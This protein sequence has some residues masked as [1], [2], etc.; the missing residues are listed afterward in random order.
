MVWTVLRTW[1]AIVDRTSKTI[2]SISDDDLQTEI[3]PGRNR[4]YY[5][6][7]HLA[8]TQDRLFPLLRLGDRVYPQLDEQF[9]SNA[10]RKYP[11]GEA[12]PTE[13]RRAWMEVNATLAEAFEVL[14][15]EDWLERHGSVSAEAFAK[16][17]HR[18]RLAVLISRLN[19]VAYHEGQIQVVR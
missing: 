8:A 11:G 18:N 16:E 3:A 19:H 2:A 5:L 4:L 1:Q 17:P 12:A 15:P 10:D 13:L 6:L 14:K 9:I 7:G